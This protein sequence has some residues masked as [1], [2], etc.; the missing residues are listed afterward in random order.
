MVVANTIYRSTCFNEFRDKIVLF[1]GETD[2]NE[3]EL[4][5]AHS[6]GFKKAITLLEVLSVVA[7]VSDWALREFNNDETK[8]DKIKN[9]LLKRFGQTEEEFL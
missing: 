9:D 4:E 2:S 5:L 7:D 6:Y 8:K 3:E 1:A